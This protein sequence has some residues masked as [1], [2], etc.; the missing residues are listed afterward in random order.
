MVT[1][2]FLVSHP[3]PNPTMSPLFLIIRSPLWSVRPSNGCFALQFTRPTFRGRPSS[4]IFGYLAHLASV[5]GRWGRPTAGG[6][7]L[8]INWIG[9]THSSVSNPEHQTVCYAGQ[10][11]E[12]GKKYAPRWLFK[13]GRVSTKTGNPPRSSMQV[14]EYASMQTAQDTTWRVQQRCATQHTERQHNTKDTPH[15]AGQNIRNR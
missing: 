13:E 14:C 3:A 5:S 15:I 7:E 11:L 9:V 2:I 1:S 12:P 10:I 4:T 6:D 8:I